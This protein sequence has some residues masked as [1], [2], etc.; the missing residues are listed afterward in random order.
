MGL[1]VLPYL[2]VADLKEVTNITYFAV[3]NLD[4]AYAHLRTEVV[5]KQRQWKALSACVCGT[6]LGGLPWTCMR[7]MYMLCTCCACL[8]VNTCSSSRRVRPCR[9]STPTGLWSDSS[10]PC[11]CHAGSRPVAYLSLCGICWVS[12]ACREDKM[13]IIE[14]G[15]CDHLPEEGDLRGHCLMWW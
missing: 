14:T 7:A 15:M 13:R 6:K 12:P 11:S 4:M 2:Q 9:Q 1:G 3:N 10:A 5:G 8:G